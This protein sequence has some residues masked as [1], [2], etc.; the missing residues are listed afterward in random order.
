MKIKSYEVR[1]AIE[2]ELASRRLEVKRIR[3]AR[4]DEAYSAVPELKELDARMRSEAIRLG[5]TIMN[6]KSENASV[7]AELEIRLLQKKRAEL[8]R[9]NGFSE[10]HLDFEYL[11]PDCRD[12]GRVNGELCRCV[13]Q[14]AVNTAFEDSGIDRVQNF[15]AFDLSL[16]KEA[17]NRS[18]MKKI[19]DAAVAYADSFPDNEKKDILYFGMPGVGKTYLLNCIG[20]RVLERGYSVLKINAHRLIRL[21]MDG[22]R[23]APEDRPDFS[24]PDLLIIDDLGT[25][26]MIPNI[27]V[28]TLLSLVC[29]RQEM[30]KATL[31]ATN[32][33]IVSDGSGVE[34][35]QS[36]YGERFASRL[37]A[38]ARVK[39]QGVLTENLRLSAR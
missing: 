6:S 37:I 29:E 4:E 34:T 9:S 13:L 26:P 36:R 18:A 16:Q 11:C 31:F 19:L 24:M 39:I 14:L 33:D 2:D 32:L 27:T 25:E 20:A 30:N 7:E 10:D 35:L 3:Q 23:S 38:P 28:E 17:N 1:R 8:L 22:F 12:T 15:E 5:R 21:T